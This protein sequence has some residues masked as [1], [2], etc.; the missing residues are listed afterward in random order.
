MIILF[1]NFLRKLHTV[2]HSGCINLHSHQQCTMVP[3][4]PHPCQHLLFLVFLMTAVLTGVRWYLIVVWFAFPW[5]VM[6]S[7]FSC[8]CCPFVCLLWE[9]NLYSNPLPIF[10]IRIFFS[11]CYWVVWV[12]YIFWILSSFQIDSLQIF[13]PI[14]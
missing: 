2:F 7:T 4:S 3:F 14:L 13:S 5:L 1:L 6:S 8:T 11:F 10:L 12:P 9:K